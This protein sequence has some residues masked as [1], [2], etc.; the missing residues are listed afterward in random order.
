MESTEWPSTGLFAGMTKSLGNY[1]ECVRAIGPSFRGQYC[2]AQLS[3]DYNDS[4]DSYSTDIL[5]GQEMNKMSVWRV[6]KMVGS[7]EKYVEIER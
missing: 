3:Y 1:E 7:N 5:S 4:D 6:M 2:L